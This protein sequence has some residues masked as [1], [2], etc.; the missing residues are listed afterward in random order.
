MFV[1]CVLGILV[2]YIMYGALQEAIFHASDMKQHSSFLTLL[3]FAM[4]SFL[5]FFELRHQGI[6]IFASR[7]GFGLYCLMALLTLGTIAFSNASVAY[8]NY[9][10]QV[11]FK[12]CKMIP[13]MI[14]GLVIQRKGY[15]AL[16]VSAVV[17]MTAGLVSFTM[18]DITVQPFFT[19][20]GVILVSMALCCDGALG[21]F[22]ELAMRKLKCSNTELLFYPYFLGFCF[23]LCGLVL[24]GRVVPS[25]IHFNEHP[26]QT[27][28]YGFV[29][30]LCG[31]FGVHFVLCLVQSHGALTAVTVTTF[32]K[33]VTM[34]ISF[35]MFEKRFSM[36]YVW[37]GL[38]VL[39]GLY[40]SLYNKNRKSW[41][42]F[43]RN[44]LYK[45]GIL[46]QP[47]PTLLPQ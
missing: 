25:V 13:V 36:G 1:V 3:Q 26:F 40:L 8:L 18:V 47:V 22:Q 17:L 45:L 20:W 42:H 2:T 34:M 10:T 16:E 30:S 9:P 7:V 38:L 31:Y 32:R 4:Y 15:N 14:G 46:R 21:N 24:T 29:F 19:A 41:D 33:A 5:A 27:Y 43:V 6:S 12:C 35:S 39:L 37:S 44:R 11:I 28:G 23:L